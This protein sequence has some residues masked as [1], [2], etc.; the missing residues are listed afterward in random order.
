MPGT[1]VGGGDK[2]GNKANKQKKPLPLMECS[3][4]CGETGNK[5]TPSL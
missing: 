4:L 5:L 3:F 2:A 1:V